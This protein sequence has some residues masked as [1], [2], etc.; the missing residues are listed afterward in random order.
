MFPSKQC[1]V[2]PYDEMT[3]PWKLR[4]VVKKRVLGE[5]LTDEEIDILKA[6]GWE[7]ITTEEH[8]GWDNQEFEVHL[9]ILRDLFD[10]PR[11]VGASIINRNA[12]VKTETG[13]EVVQTR[14]TV[15][16][17]KNALVIVEGKYL[18]GN[19]GK[20][21]DYTVRLD[22]PADQIRLQFAR[23]CAKVS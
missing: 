2:I 14:R 6:R 5:E 13:R 19:F 23:R 8:V 1:V 3:L 15:L 12:Y 9:K 20:Y 18:A 22:G 16:D 11:T 17:S 7:N 4:S 21:A 10:H